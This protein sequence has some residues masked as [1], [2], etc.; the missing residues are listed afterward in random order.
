[1]KYIFIV[2]YPEY[3]FN[4]IMKNKSVKYH[5]VIAKN[6]RKLRTQAKLSQETLAEGVGCS[7]EFIS[8]IENFKEKV[9]LNM[10]LKVAEMFK[11][12]PAELFNQK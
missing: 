12:N 5:D 3:S 4:D 7:R 6:I 1:M 9:S 11:I 2:L 10:L 8:R